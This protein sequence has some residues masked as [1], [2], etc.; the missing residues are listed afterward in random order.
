MGKFLKVASI[1]VIALG[2]VCSL[3]LG[4]NTVP[5]SPM[6]DMMGYMVPTVS[7]DF[8]QAIFGVFAS[9]VAGLLLMGIS[10]II[11]IEDEK[12]EN[13]RRLCARFGIKPAV[14]ENSNANRKNANYRNGNMQQTG[15]QSQGRPMNQGQPVNQGQSMNQGQSTNQGQKVSHGQP[16]NQPCNGSKMNPGHQGDQNNQ[17]G[18]NSQNSQNSQTDQNNQSNQGGSPNKFNQID[19]DSSMNGAEVKKQEVPEKKVVHQEPENTIH[20]DYGDE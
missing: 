12:R 5:A 6:D 1:V 18:Q 17:N 7:Y 16:M 11:Y 4:F 19:S 2:V 3:V 13:T 8:A 20:E 14:T 15:F 10:E 9:V